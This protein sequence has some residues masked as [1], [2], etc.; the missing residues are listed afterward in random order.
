MEVCA[1]EKGEMHDTVI[2]AKVNLIK[3]YQ[4]M[5][6][7]LCDKLEKAKKGLQGCER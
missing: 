6:G 3:E 1:V 2:L 5:P 4:R 7:Q